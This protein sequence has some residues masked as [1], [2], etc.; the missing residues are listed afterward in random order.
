MLMIMSFENDVQQQMFLL[1]VRYVDCSEGF[2]LLM[3]GCAM[4]VQMARIC[5]QIIS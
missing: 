1:F 4:G 3:Q 2:I 5:K